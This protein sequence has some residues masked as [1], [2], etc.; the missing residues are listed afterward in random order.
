LERGV[1]PPPQKEELLEKYA[2]A[3][4]IVR[5]SSAWLEFFDLAVVARGEI[6]KDLMTDE[7][8]VVKLPVLF[9][10]LKGSQI[11]SAKLDA[12]VEKIRRS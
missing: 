2:K 8:V 4:G 12:L 9:R 5:G 7:E 3:L 6:P 11:T 1:F 10:T